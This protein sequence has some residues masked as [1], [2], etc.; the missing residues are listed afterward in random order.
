MF[1]VLEEV[2]VVAEL[3]TLPL[4]EMVASLESMIAAEALMSA[5][6]INEVVRLPLVSAW[7]TPA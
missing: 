2:A 3:A 5:L 1:P 7:T 4:V 6:T